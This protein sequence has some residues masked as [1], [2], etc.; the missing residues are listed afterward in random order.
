[1]GVQSFDQMVPVAILVALQIAILVQLRSA[2]ADSAAAA[3]SAADSAAAS[4]SAAADSAAATA[5][6][7]AKTNCIQAEVQLI[8]GYVPETVDFWNPRSR[9][10]Q[11]LSLRE[12]S[13]DDVAKYYG[14]LQKVQEV[15][16]QLVKVRDKSDDKVK[17]SDNEVE[18][19]DDEVETSDDEV[20]AIV[21]D[22]TKTTYYHATCIVTGLRGVGGHVIVSHNLGRNQPSATFE[23][24]DLDVGIHADHFRN[25]I[26]LA[27]GLEQA[28]E[29]KQICFMPTPENLDGKGRT[30]FLKIWDETVRNLPVFPRPKNTRQCKDEEIIWPDYAAQI[31]AYS[32]KENGFKFPKGKVP[33]TRILS[34]HASCSFVHAVNMGWIDPKEVK[35]PEVFGTPLKDDTLHLKVEMLITSPTKRRDVGWSSPK[36]ETGSTAETMESEEYATSASSGAC[37]EAETPPRS[38]R[39]TFHEANR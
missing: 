23:Q 21:E 36:A 34:H 3:E 5:A 2:A 31:G 25:T 12:C 27:K 28:Y 9:N 8:R 6:I 20:E 7:L 19:S 18:A 24:L 32:G 17:T 33:Y 26:L 29:K 4:A 38:L 10:A 16:G 22:K 14:C 37:D 13:R 15:N 1:M 35:P 30:Y 11:A 39:D